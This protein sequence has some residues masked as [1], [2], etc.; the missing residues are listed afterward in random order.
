MRPAHALLAALGAALG[1]AGAAAVRVPTIDIVL[2]ALAGAAIVG[3]THAA[4]EVWLDARRTAYIAAALA[5]A[6]ALAQPSFVASHAALALALVP[7]ALALLS[8]AR[9]AAPLASTIALCAAVVISPGIGLAA[10][11]LPLW[12]AVDPRG[13]WAALPPALLALL[14]LGEPAASLSMRV[15]LLAILAL[16]G[17]AARMFLQEASLRA[18]TRRSLLR[19]CAAIPVFG[20]L[21]LLAR[22]AGTQHAVDP[23]LADVL[24]PAAIA[25]GGGVLVAIAG[26]GIVLVYETANAARPALAG[27]LVAGLAGAL[28]AGGP[29]VALAAPAL[30]VGFAVA[31]SFSIAE[32]GGHAGPSVGRRNGG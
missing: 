28:V 11:T 25:L 23:A 1:A 14:P 22:E 16:A 21:A 30:L 20:I 4:V 15:V 18:G 6:V 5:G 12:S 27:L 3:G 7:P 17:V 32:L 13:R 29:A 9:P 2:F 8:D 10:A 26:A 24:V 31:L 19:L